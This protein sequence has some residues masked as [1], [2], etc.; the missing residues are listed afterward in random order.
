GDLAKQLADAVSCRASAEDAQSQD[1]GAKAKDLR[2]LETARVLLQSGARKEA[3]DAAKALRDSK[4]PEVQTAARNLLIETGWFR[5]LL[6]ERLRGAWMV[7]AAW[8]ASLLVGLF[9]VLH[10]LRLAWDK[11][12][13]ARWRK[14]KPVRWTLLTIGDPNNFGA[15]DIVLDAL[16]RAPGDAKRPMW[17]AVNLLLAL[18]DP[19]GS[20]QSEAAAVWRDFLIRNG[21][22]PEAGAEDF[23]R[24]DLFEGKAADTA[25]ADAFQNLQ[26]TVGGVGVNVVGKLLNA[27][28]DWWSANAPSF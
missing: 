25:L 1:A 8:I 15:Q 17:S 11:I 12:Q 6:E 16:K 7:D 2:S 18:Q 13:M 27:I 23:K 20:D 26:I 5:S 14:G 24:F 3:V 22:A 9:A 10:I 28:G 19:F 4:Y 21:K